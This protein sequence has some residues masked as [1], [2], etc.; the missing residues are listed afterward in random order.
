MPHDIL[1]PDGWATPKGYANGIAATGRHVFVGG[2]I[3]WNAQCVFESD[4]LV[5]QV[6]QAL[7]NAL[8]VLACAG[9][10]PEHVTR[11]TW[12]LTDRKEYK[13][14]LKEIGEAYRAAIFRP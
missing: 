11:M 5:A 14:R 3:G 1:Q 13:T 6:R 4:D 12:Y 10:G 7:D 8:A 2:Q 9:G